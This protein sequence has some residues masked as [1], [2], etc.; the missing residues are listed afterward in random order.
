MGGA[1][2]G[3]AMTAGFT[4]GS[5]RQVAELAAG[6]PHGTR[7]RYLAGCKCF[8][9]RRANSDYERVRQAARAAGD[10]NGIISSVKARHH[11]RML[12]GR[13]V[14]RNAVSAAT[15]CSRTILQKIFSGSR[16]H[17]RARTERKILGVTPACASDGTLTGAAPTW[18]L[19]D[20]LVAL[21]Y[22]KSLLAARLG[23]KY[24]AIQFSKTFVRIG[25]AARVRKLHR[26]LSAKESLEALRSPRAKIRAQ[27]KRIVHILRDDE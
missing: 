10:W 19:I 15:D 21:G 18:A 2:G 13:G 11:L 8:H 25:T 12:S 6:K 9:C 5:L 16:K 14:G 26:A 17:I 24:G 20:E 3:G 23:S 7:L 27:P 4:L 1:A 22:T